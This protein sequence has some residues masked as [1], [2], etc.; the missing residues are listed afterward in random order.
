MKDK[1]VLSLAAIAAV[2]VL[3]LFWVYTGHNEHSMALAVGVIAALAGYR[4]GVTR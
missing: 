3:E 1:T 2:T 4:V